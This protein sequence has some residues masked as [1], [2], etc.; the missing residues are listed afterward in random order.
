LAQKV[1]K[2]IKPAGTGGTA[3][4]TKTKRASVKS[5]PQPITVPAKKKVAT[6]SVSKRKAPKPPKSVRKEIVTMETKRKKSAPSQTIAPVPDTASGLLRPTKSSN[7]A[8]RHL[9]KGIEL[10][11]RRD[12]KKAHAELKSLC[13]SYPG[14][15]EILARARS[16]IMICEREEASRKKVEAPTDQLYAMGVMEHNKANYDAAISYYLR[17]LKNN[18]DS[19]YIY[20][21]I[22]ASQAMKG[23]LKESMI[24]LKKAIELNRDSR[25][26]ARNDEDFSVFGEDE[27]FADLV[28]LTRKQDADLQ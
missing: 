1:K 8:L 21:S 25:I 5:A 2:K 11:F 13:S 16:Y 15:T 27:A 20:Y 12:F 7:A 4:D 22:A 23:N 6:G 10:I 9:E 3:K 26:Y 24:N 19:D 17:S 14:E 28:G 18:P